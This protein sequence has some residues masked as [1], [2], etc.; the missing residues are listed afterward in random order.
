MMPLLLPHA[1]DGRDLA[2]PHGEGDRVAPRRVSRADP[3]GFF[4]DLPAP[5]PDPL[6][7]LLVSLAPIDRIRSFVTCLVASGP[8]SRRR[9]ACTTDEPSVMASDRRTARADAASS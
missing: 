1:S 5:R 4:M 9:G 2:T 6:G 7:L 8:W 3:D